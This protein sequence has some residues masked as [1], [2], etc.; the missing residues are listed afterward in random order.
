ML[1]SCLWGEAAA[2]DARGVDCRWD[3]GEGDVDFAEE[4]VWNARAG[5]VEA[6]EGDG[7]GWGWG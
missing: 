4:D 3:V 2:A 5:A 1:G 7:G 6:V